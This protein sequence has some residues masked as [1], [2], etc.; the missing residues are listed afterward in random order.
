MPR[1]TV[2]NSISADGYFTGANGD[3]SWAHGTD[4]NDKEWNDFVSGNAGGGGALVLG[5]V[6]YDMMVAYWPT[7][8]AAKAM[9]KVAEGMNKM[10]K[11]VFSKSL[12]GSSWQ[13][14]RVVKS[15]PVSEIRRLKEGSGPD[16]VILGSGSIVC[17]LTEEHL[18]DAYQFV[19]VPV[20]LGEGRTMFEG[21][22]DRVKLERTSE[23]AF[24]NGNVLLSYEPKAA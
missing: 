22:R 13:N 21:V 11:I 2:F 12:D 23:R 8:D 15:D 14:T 1:L 9:P 17:R 16:M 19:I 24:K 5:R 7:P 20:V 6:T 4:P 3:L 18:I 10:Q